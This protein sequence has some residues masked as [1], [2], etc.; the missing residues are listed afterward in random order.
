MRPRAEGPLVVVLY[1]VPQS[2]K[3][4]RSALMPNKIMLKPKTEPYFYVKQGPFT[5]A[6]PD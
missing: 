5:S 1:L 2:Q 3:T 6:D 4:I